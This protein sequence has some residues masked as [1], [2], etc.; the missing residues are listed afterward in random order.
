VSFH[1]VSIN[2][3]PDLN[4][5]DVIVACGIRDQGVTSLADLGLSRSMAEL[6]A[7]LAAGFSTHFGQ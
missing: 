5:Y 3:A 6:D 1:G 7:A 2:V 4:H